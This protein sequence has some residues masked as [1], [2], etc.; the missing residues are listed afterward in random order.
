MR[1]TVGS[2]SECMLPLCEQILRGIHVETLYKDLKQNIHIRRQCVTGEVRNRHTHQLEGDIV[3]EVIRLPF[4][5]PGLHHHIT[6]A[7]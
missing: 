4:D 7:Y 5:C 2:I 6:I 3:G 1:F